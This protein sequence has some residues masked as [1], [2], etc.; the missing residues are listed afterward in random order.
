MYFEMGTALLNI[1]A[2]QL[3]EVTVA[4]G[5]YHLTSKSNFT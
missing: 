3:F 2:A 4:F 1:T 5:Y